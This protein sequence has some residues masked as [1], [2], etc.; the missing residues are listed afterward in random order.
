MFVDLGNLKRMWTIID[1]IGTRPCFRLSVK[2]EKTRGGNEATAGG[3][4]T[5]LREY[6]LD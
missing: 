3:S 1:A 2:I 6:L 5:P 4:T